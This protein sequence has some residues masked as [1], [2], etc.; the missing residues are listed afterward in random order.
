MN[1]SSIDTNKMSQ[2]LFH[3]DF[4]NLTFSQKAYVIQQCLK[5]AEAAKYVVS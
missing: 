2:A 4:D 5:Q 3:V 1:M